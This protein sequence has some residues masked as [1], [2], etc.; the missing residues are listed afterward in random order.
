[1]LIGSSKHSRSEAA[2]TEVYRSLGHGAAKSACEDGRIREFP[3]EIGEFAIIFASLQ[4]V[5]HLADY[6][7]TAR[8]R[9]SAVEAGIDRAE[10]AIEKL[11]Q[12]PT[13]HRR[14]FASWVLF[15]NATRSR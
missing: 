5:R 7:P 8:L 10:T 13:K 9:K 1:M 11:Y 2:W 14:A 12:A 6:D 4:S 3:P 15:R